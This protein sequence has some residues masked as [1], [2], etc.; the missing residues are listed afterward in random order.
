MEYVVLLFYM[1]VVRPAMLHVMET[2][3]TELKVSELKVVRFS[4]KVTWID[5]IWIEII[6]G[7][8]QVEWLVKVRKA[9]LR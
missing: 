7:G 5:K 8:A 4:L 3:E 2:T 6:R 9:R 1:R